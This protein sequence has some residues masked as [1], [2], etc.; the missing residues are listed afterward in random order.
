M[1]PRSSPIASVDCQLPSGR[2]STKPRSICTGPPK[3]TGASRS[4]VVGERN[5]DLL[6]QRRQRHVDRL[7]DDD[8]ERAVLVVL[9]DVRQR[10]REMRIGHGRHG[11]QEMV[12]QIDRTGHGVAIVIRGGCRHNRT[13]IGLRTRS[14]SRCH[15]HPERARWHLRSGSR[16]SARSPGAAWAKLTVMHGFVDYTSALVWIQADAPGPIEVSWRVE[17]DD[18]E[19]RA[20]FDA[21]AADENVV[22]A[23]LSGLLPGRRCVRDQRRRR[24]ARR[25]LRAQPRWTRAAMRATSRSRSAPAP[26]WPTPI[27]SGADRTY[28]GGYEIFDAIA[29]KKPDLMVWLGDNLYFQPPDEFDPASMAA[30]Y[31]RQRSQPLQTLLTAT[32]HLAIWDDHDFGPNDADMSYVMKGDALALFRRYWANPSFGL[33]EIP[34]V[35]GY[36]RFGDVDLFLLDDRYYRSANLL[37]DGPDKTMF[38]AAQLAWLRNALASS[39]AAD[40]AGRQRHAVLEPH[41]SFRGWH[42]FSVEQKAFADWLIAQRVDGLIF[43]SGDRHFTELLK[44]ARAGAYPLYEFTS[45]PLTSGTFDPP[46]EQQAVSMCAGLVPARPARLRPRRALPRAAR[47]RRRALRLRV[48]PRD[49]RRDRP[50]APTA[51]SSSSSRASSR[52]R[53]RSPGR[54]AA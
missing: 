7:V 40:Q 1:S 14:P 25:R 54:A 33:P 22:L 13:R 4:A 44:V 20:T 48:R 11:D 35:F 23:R 16:R 53:P 32:S 41:Q 37:I 51:V 19:R 50:T 5:V 34:G 31:R 26:F 6:E 47:R 8:A 3:C 45:S 15:V 12:G 43:V 10:M 52:W 30:R 49:P 9:A 27:R 21:R 17:G 2:C 42:H 24:S 39:N 29:A 38:G 36:A 46:G 28:G 18:R